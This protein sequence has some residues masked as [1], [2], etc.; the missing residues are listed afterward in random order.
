MFWTEPYKIIPLTKQ[1][2][3]DRSSHRTLT[4]ETPTHSESENVMSYD[5]RII[6]KNFQPKIDKK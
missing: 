2:N 1:Q 6:P 5:L 3:R 4:M